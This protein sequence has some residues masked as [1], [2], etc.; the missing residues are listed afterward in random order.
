MAVYSG[1]NI[2]SG[3]MHQSLPDLRSLKVLPSKRKTN[4]DNPYEKP[5]NLYPD[6]GSW[7]DHQAVSRWS[8][9][10]SVNARL[11][12]VICITL[13]YV[14]YSILVTSTFVCLVYDIKEKA[15]IKV[16]GQSSWYIFGLSSLTFA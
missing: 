13:H 14:I 9:I 1:G 10:F 5:H 8:N 12:N 2:I 6:L 3:P 7:N 16:K 15:E 11:R 4:N